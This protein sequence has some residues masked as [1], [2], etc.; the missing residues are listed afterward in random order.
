MRVA[1]PKDPMTYG[2]ARQAMRPRKSEKGLRKDGK[3]AKKA[4]V[5]KNKKSA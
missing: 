2:K 3:R 4:T 1:D 5:A